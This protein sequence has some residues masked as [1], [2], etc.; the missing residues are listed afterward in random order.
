MNFRM[1]FGFQNAPKIIAFNLE[2]E[3]FSLNT[4]VFVNTTS[5]LRLFLT[6]ISGSFGIGMS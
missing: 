1:G 2:T 6:T 3:K 5:K 4:L